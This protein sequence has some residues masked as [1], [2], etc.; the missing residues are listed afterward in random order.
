LKRQ[1]IKVEILDVPVL[2]PGSEQVVTCRISNLQRYP[3]RKIA[4]EAYLVNEDSG[5]RLEN[6]YLSKLPR[7]PKQLLNGEHFDVDL[8]ITIPEEFFDSPVPVGI[9]VSAT[10]EW[11]ISKV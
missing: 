7:H 6:N 8:K 3:V 5:E 1:I 10:G 2:A 11:Y 4:L 9:N